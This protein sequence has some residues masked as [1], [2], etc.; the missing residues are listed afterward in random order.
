MLHHPNRTIRTFS[1]LLRSMTSSAAPQTAKSSSSSCLSP[2]VSLPTSSP[3][4][5]P[6]TPIVEPSVTPF[7]PTS[8]YS[9]ATSSSAPSSSS[10]SGKPVPIP[11]NGVDYRG[12]I[13]LA[14]MVRSG[15]LPTRMIALRYGADLVWGKCR[16]LRFQLQTF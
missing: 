4:L 16:V 14:P 15:E 7:T 9:T 11:D 6:T 1:A 12:K 5:I 8:Y 13:V 3:G 2:S 10:S